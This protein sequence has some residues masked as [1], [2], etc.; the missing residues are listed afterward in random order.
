MCLPSGVIEHSEYESIWQSVLYEISS[1][2]VVESENWTC[3]HFLVPDRVP[4]GILSPQVFLPEACNPVFLASSD[5]KLLFL[6]CHQISRD[7]TCYGEELKD[8]WGWFETGGQWGDTQ[9][10]KE[11][12][13]QQE[14]GF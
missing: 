5:E 3:S 14:G 1:K 11:M 4:D 8:I 2:N 7:Y 12:T 9:G 10:S 13:E 6:L